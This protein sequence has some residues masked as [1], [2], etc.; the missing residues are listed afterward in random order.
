[1]L[2]NVA[3]LLDE[4]EFKLQ[5][6]LM[7]WNIPLC[8][9]ELSAAALAWTLVWAPGLAY[10][11]DATS[12]QPGIPSDGRKIFLTRCFVCHGVNG[13]GKG[14][15]AAGL[16]ADP[17][18][19]TDPDW[20]KSVTDSRIETVIK[21]GGQAIGESSAM[22]ANSDLSDAQVASLLQFIRNLSKR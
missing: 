4:F 16:G 15:S 6:S 18:N 21:Y 10:G 3:Q 19:F 8:S 12:T 11:Q 14:P 1:M 9:I 5:N 7:A 20:Q 17:R 13:N 22:P 2:R